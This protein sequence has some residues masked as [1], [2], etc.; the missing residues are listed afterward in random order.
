MVC[1]WDAPHIYR[2]MKIAIESSLNCMKAHTQAP[3][4]VSDSTSHV[5]TV[6]VSCIKIIK[7]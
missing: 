2:L 1:M 7:V 6:I 3:L 4:L 5:E